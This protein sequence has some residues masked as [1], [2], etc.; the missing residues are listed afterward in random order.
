VSHLLGYP[1]KILE[2]SEADLDAFDRVC[3]R[4]AGFNPRVASEWADGY[5]TALATGYRRVEMDEWLPRM[6][7]D[8]FA[9][10]FADPVDVDWARQTLQTRVKVLANHLDAEALLDDP[11]A[12]RL[13]PLV[14]V[15][16]DE[17]RRALVEEQGVAADEAA[18]MT[19]GALWSLGFFDAIADF[20]DD[21]Q[22]P[23]RAD[24]EARA[25]F[26]ALLQQVSVLQLPDAD[27]TFNSHITQYWKDRV[28][29]RDDL[30]D[31][32]C[33]AIQDLRVWWIDHAPRP[34]TRRVEAAPGRN[35][36][37]PCGSGLKY[38]KCHGKTV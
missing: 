38:K 31:E 28:P 7:G 23:G 24:A 13:Q 32:A 19:T 8:A 17:A 30:L 3:Q 35:D 4:M 33:F 14:S 26:D 25:A 2:S 9:R 21:W 36:P 11:E 16:D 15:W 22:V 6:V 29:T 27:G 12:L 37:C 18:T 20:A 5:L 34:V 1:V 10:A